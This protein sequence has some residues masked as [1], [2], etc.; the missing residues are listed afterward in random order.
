[1]Q[2]PNPRELLVSSLR[3]FF[4][5]P[6]L[7]KLG[8][9][10]IIE[11]MLQGRFSLS[12]FPKV[13]NIK[14]FD[15]VVDYLE[16]IGFLEGSDDNYSLTRVGRS[17]MGRWGSFALLYSYRE[18]VDRIDELLTE[19]QATP[20]ACDRRYNVI[21]SGL[22]NGRKFFPSGLELLKDY[23]VA[24]I[25]DL[26]CG[27]GEFLR[28]CRESYPHARLNA[29]DISH[30]A[31]DEAKKKLDGK[32]GVRFTVTDAM[33]VENWQ[34]LL[35]ENGQDAGIEVISMWYLLHEVSGN[36]VDRLVS[37]L[38]QIRSQ[39]PD[40]HLL[41][42]EIVRTGKNMSVESV[43]MSIIPEFMLFHDFS[44]QGVLSYEEWNDVWERSPYEIAKSVEF[45]MVTT[46]SGKSIPSAFVYHLIPS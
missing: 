32:V 6:I 30:I 31:I 37:F 14:S 28:V 7:V 26:C 12:D 8:E 20:P 18:L 15:L 11:I 39:M 35:G 13:K 41:V 9:L 43:G 34:G 44:G 24:G 19:D 16:S 29:C 1:M 40:A 33:E 22:T 3:G 23:K 36:S 17:I 25:T 46:D 38:K 4:L 45:D 10:G 27:D 21:G 42:G 5:C 2:E